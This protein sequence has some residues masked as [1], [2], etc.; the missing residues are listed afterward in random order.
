MFMRR[1]YCVRTDWQGAAV[2]ELVLSSLDPKPR[3]H[4][5]K[6]QQMKMTSLTLDLGSLLMPGLLLT[7]LSWLPAVAH[8][9]SLIASV[10]A[11]P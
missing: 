9:A 2:S 6:A 5:L 8:Y 3:L 11:H 10:A 1:I 7:K 4:L